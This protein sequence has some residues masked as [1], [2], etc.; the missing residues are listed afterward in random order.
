MPLPVAVRVGF[1]VAL[2]H[3]YG[4]IPTGEGA[5]HFLFG[6]GVVDFHLPVVSQDD[7]ERAGWQVRTLERDSDA[8]AAFS[9]PYRY[10]QARPCQTWALFHFR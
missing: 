1:G 10:S 7:A 9:I 5:T 3:A 8:L 2:V 6:Y 4:V